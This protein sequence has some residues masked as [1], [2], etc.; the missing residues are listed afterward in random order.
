VTAPLGREPQR[1]QR[2]QRTQRRSLLSRA[3][4]NAAQNGLVI[5]RYSEGSLVRRANDER[6]FAAL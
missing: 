2:A 5:L 6:F 4:V 1:T 3:D